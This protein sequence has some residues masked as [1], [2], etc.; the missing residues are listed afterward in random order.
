MRR[1]AAVVAAVAFFAFVSSSCATPRL[2]RDG[3]RSFSVAALRSAGLRS[4]S[5]VREATVERCT[6]EGAAGW[7]T[8]T[9]TSVGEVSMCVSRS[10]GRVLSVR[11]PGMTDAQFARLEAY[12]GETAEDRAT[13]LA[14]GS[15]VL[16]LLGVTL[17]LLLQLRP[18]GPPS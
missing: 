11:D 1:V 3:A 7:R 18:P 9:D 2:D 14:I 4:V 15:A 10:Q 16:L 6:V 5:T 12:R 17:R 13:P 8:V